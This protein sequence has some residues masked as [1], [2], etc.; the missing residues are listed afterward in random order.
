MPKPLRRILVL[1]VLTLVYVLAFPR[2]TGTEPLIERQWVLSIDADAADAGAA[3]AGA[4]ESAD[5]REARVIPFRLG[6]QFGYFTSDG[7]LRHIEQVRYG[8]AQ[9]SERFANYSVISDNVVL[10]DPDGT[11]ARSIAAHGYPRLDHGRLYIFAPG[12]SAVSEWT[13][14]GRQVWTRDFLSVLTDLDA[15]ETRTAVGLLDGSVHLL[16]E[17]GEELFAYETEGARIPVTLA[18]ALGED[19][20]VLAAVAGID[21]QKL[22]L[23]ERHTEG[24][25]PVFQLEL[26][27]DYRRPILLDFL[28]DGATLAV[29]QPGGLLLYDRSTES[30]DRIDLGGEVEEVTALPQLDLVLAAARVAPG[31]NGASTPVRRLQATVWPDRPLFSQAMATDD[32]FLSAAGSRIY[33]GARGRLLC[34]ELVQG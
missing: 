21:P 1:I 16:D 7:G 9:D 3:D 4:A 25:F 11:F 18:I 30:F 34:V 27:S 8:I 2:S 26:D 29:E 32:V 5:G 6:S 13:V 28:D 23:F 19:E 14:D 24:F 22:I 15:G 33:I 10:Q 17:D 31:E 12:G 20:D